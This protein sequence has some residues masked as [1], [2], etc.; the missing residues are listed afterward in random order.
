MLKMLILLSRFS[1]S[2]VKIK[3]R[4]A[5]TFL[6]IWLM[7]VVICKQTLLHRNQIVQYFENY[8]CYGDDRDH[9][10]KHLHSCTKFMKN[11]DLKKTRIIFKDFQF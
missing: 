2:L 3:V 7:S 5:W 4:S 6:V 1:E 10:R 9:F 11:N 8:K